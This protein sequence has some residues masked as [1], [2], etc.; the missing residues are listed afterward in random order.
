M[1]KWRAMADDALQ[2]R[3][4]RNTRDTSSGATGAFVPSV[5]SVLSPLATLKLWRGSLA[6]L[7]PCQPR[8]MPM[9]RWQTL[10]DASHW[11]LAGFGEQAARD[12]WSTSCIFGVWPDKPGW[13]GL[14]DRLGE[15]RSL[16]MTADSARWRSLGVPESFNRGSYPE[17]SP[18]W[19]FGQ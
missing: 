18:W 9:G 3:D 7:D 6:A 15:S 16:V 17:L 8:D 2:G 1:S 19:G 14:I 13:G 4:K 12:G 11:W 10:Y 5:P